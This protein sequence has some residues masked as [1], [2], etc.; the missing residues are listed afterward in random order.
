MSKSTLGTFLN[1]NK[2]LLIGFVGGVSLSIVSCVG[3]STLFNSPTVDR[4][5]N[6]DMNG[7]VSVTDQNRS[8]DTNVP[9]QDLELIDSP[10][11]HRKKLL[12][13]LA[14]KDSEEL[15]GMIDESANLSVEQ[16]PQEVQDILFRHL[17]EF[18][19]NLA[20]AQVWLQQDHRWLH[21]LAIVFDVWASV[22]LD[23]AVE[24]AATLES[25]F[26]SLAVRSILLRRSDLSNT[27]RNEIVQILGN[28]FSANEILSE[29]K[30]M[31]LLDRPNAAWDVVLN[32]D[33]SDEVQVN[34]LVEIASAWI[35]IEGTDGY[36]PLFQRLYALDV[37]DRYRLTARVI[38]RIVAGDPQSAWEQAKTLS[39][40]E[41]QMIIPQVVKVWASID[42]EQA[43]E[44]I[45]QIENTDLQHAAYNSLIEGWSSTQPADVL[46]NLPL[47]PPE[48]RNAAIDSAIHQLARN[49]S[50]DKARK[51]IQ[52]L[53]E[54]GENVA[55]ASMN[56]IEI[57]SRSDP[58]SALNWLVANTEIDGRYSRVSLLT[59]I[60]RLA[61]Q[62][63]SQAMEFASGNEF[64]SAPSLTIKRT[65][66]SALASD[67]RFDSA[68]EMLREFQE[69]L[70]VY[71]YET[72]GRNL[73]EFDRG[74]EA[75][76]LAK[77]LPESG[78][79]NYFQVLSRTWFSSKPDE[80]IQNMERLPSKNVQS[81]VAQQML[82]YASSED[83]VLSSKQLE[84]LQTFLEVD[85]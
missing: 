55:R 23:A 74:I 27:E 22:N 70:D 42:R 20:L 78:W 81:I 59:V 43:F 67:G 39:T 82:D 62:D 49:Q 2:R 58:T 4:E 35:S 46:D 16:R 26:K 64:P 76:E 7:T 1:S 56:L 83:R 13:L 32:D 15:I 84:R 63:P 79:A 12:T 17:A 38:R 77:E 9:I 40:I 34:L 19:P 57:W 68:R 52:D 51:Y 69:P 44:V 6:T 30:V 47:I 8:E 80:L 53:E 48:Q 72:L 50:F 61:L 41:R 36:V 25:S 11:R 28:E 75:I 54:Q 60:D 3:V 24:S 10:S 37:S 85:Q 33:V 66:I 65:V 18:D 29:S 21:L 14:H 31:Q 71:S 5:T 45:T 73:I